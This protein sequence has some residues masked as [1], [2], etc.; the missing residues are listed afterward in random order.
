MKSRMTARY[1][2]F[3]VFRRSQEDAHLFPTSGVKFPLSLNFGDSAM[4][5]SIDFSS[6]V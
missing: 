5:N 6:I 4:G 2:H 3:V 1:Y